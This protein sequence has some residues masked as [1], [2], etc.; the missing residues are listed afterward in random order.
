MI[1]ATGNSNCSTVQL[2]GTRGDN[3]WKRQ[4]SEQRRQQI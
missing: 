1:I 2:H 3:S 4:T